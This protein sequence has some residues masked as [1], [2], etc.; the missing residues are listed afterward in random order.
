MNRDLRIV[1]TSA[2]VWCEESAYSGPQKQIP[3]CARDDK[4]DGNY[5]NC[6]PEFHMGLRPTHRD[7]NQP[8]RHGDHRENS[9]ETKLRVLCV[10]VVN[11]FRRSDVRASFVRGGVEEPAPSEAEGIP[12]AA[13]TLSNVQSSWLAMLNAEC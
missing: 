5:L 11:D 8:R 13:A 10:S 2:W 12:I 4:C 7:E 3:R 9:A 6:H 1:V